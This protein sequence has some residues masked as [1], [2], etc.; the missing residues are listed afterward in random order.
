MSI[1]ILGGVAR[2]FELATP[3]VSTT[4]PT[5]VLLKR[6]LFDS[7]QNFQDYTFIDLCAGSGSVGF[8]A[9]SRGAN[10]VV[11][12]E[13]FKTAF[14]CLSE[15]K[16]KLNSKFPELGQIEIAN[17]DFKKWINKNRELLS[18]NPDIFIFFDPPYEKIDL[19]EELFNSVREI[20]FKGRLV[21]EACQQKTMTIDSFTAKFGEIDKLFK[22]GTSYFAIYDF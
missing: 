12:V 18:N 8:E 22:Q 7:T 11:L 16:K 1:R 14:R 13:N 9:L 21:V 2:N 4:R 10:N 5:S 19:Y 20:P 3:K 17:E 6:R 15:N